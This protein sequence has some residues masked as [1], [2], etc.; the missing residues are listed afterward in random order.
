M[1]WMHGINDSPLINLLTWLLIAVAVAV[2]VVAVGLAY[3]AIAR[4]TYLVTV[5]L[6]RL[7]HS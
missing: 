7:T 2:G 6:D 5:R 1:V 3:W 4:V